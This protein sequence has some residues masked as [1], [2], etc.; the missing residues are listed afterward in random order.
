[1]FH[2]D[3]RS[4]QKSVRL[5]GVCV[6]NLYVLSYIWAPLINSENSKSFPKAN[7]TFIPKPEK[8]NTNQKPMD[9]FHLYI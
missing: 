1:M 4:E 3:A 6:S 7:V 8:Q 5:C 9:Q 2:C